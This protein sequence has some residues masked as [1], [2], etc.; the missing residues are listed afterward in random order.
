MNQDIP[1]I[2]RELSAEEEKEY[3]E[4]MALYELTQSAG[5]QVIKGWL[6]DK[7]FHTWINPIEIDAPNGLSKQEWEWRELNAFHSAN[8]AKELLANID[9]AISRADYLG[10]VKSGEIKVKKM[11]I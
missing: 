5:W 10:K 3:R 8:N 6:Q 11:T 9:S 4:G 1:Q 2:G 7:A